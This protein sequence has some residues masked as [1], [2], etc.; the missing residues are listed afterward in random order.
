MRGTRWLLLVAILAI[1]CGVGLTYRAQKRALREHA[2]A[3]PANLPDELNSAAQKWVYS[4]TTATYTK[5]EA[6]ADD[7]REARDSSRVDLKGVTMKI[8]SKNGRTY[9][10]VRSA[11]ASFFK[12]DHR[13]RSADEVEITLNIPEQGPIKRTP[14]SIK[15]SGVELDTESG[16]VETEQPSRFVF[17]NGTGNA[18]GASYDP[19]SHQLLMKKDVRL[20]WRAKGPH[21][22]P[23]RVEG[24]SLEYHEDRSEVWLRP[25][26][27]LTRE[28]TVIEGENAVIHLED[29]P[30]GKVVRKIEV[31]NAHG[32]DAYP[33]RTLHYSA[34]ELWTELDD[35]GQ[36]RK[37]TAQTNAR[38]TAVSNS[39]ETTITAFHVEMNFTPGQGESILTSVD[40]SGNAEIRS[41]PLAAAGRPP[42]E[43]HAL[44]AEK[45]EM[46]MREG[47]R[48]ISS[49]TA[50]TPGVLEFIPNQPS[51]HHRVL[52]GNHMVILYGP[53]NRI[54]SFHAT[55]VRTQTDP[56]AE[57][58]KRKRAPR[59]TT[60]QEILASFD[61]T[62]K[63]GT[64]Q[65]T[66]D[67]R[68]EE[69]ERRAQAAKAIL[70]S[71]NDVILLETKARMWDSSGATSADRIRLDERTGAFSAEGEVN[72][73]HLPDRNPKSPEMLS[74]DEPIQ[75]QAQSMESRNRN[76]NIR[77]QGHAVLWQGANRIQ[78]DTIDLDR[79]KHSLV[80]DGNVM[81]SLW[82]QPAADAGS[83]NG[84][85]KQT[86]PP[87]LTE[88]HAPH[89][90]YT[91]SNRLAD[92][93]GGVLLQRP[94]LVVRAREIHAY[95]A[96]SGSDSRLEKA[97]AD[98]AVDIL[99]TSADRTRHGT[100]EH[101]EYYPGEQKIVLR[102]G[103]PKFADSEQGTTVAPAGLIYWVDDDRLLLNGSKDQ[104]VQTRL[105][106]KK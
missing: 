11:A 30:E 29:G 82:E 87:V 35:S 66:G 70:D 105:K 58:A 34:G 47:G 57:E 23:M 27:R 100:G 86:A 67:F 94:N 63:L 26:G 80:A 52:N 44:R 16:R 4:E 33:Q 53:Q 97:I 38:L 88:V 1:L 71:G 55:E 41:R 79:E 2:P 75:A 51:Q 20:E 96:E 90:E 6:A 76:R 50:W 13:L 46:K 102:G 32:N 62:G 21:A 93:S 45:I 40:A 91:G 84:K 85:P 78:A 25:W 28:N 61:K 7:F 69:G 95:L 17:E 42:R 19:T 37:I 68:Y 14:V 101:S 18:T 60:S 77:Y 92:Y 43:T 74:G 65:Q 81:T 59:I 54:E 73:S 12:G 83:Q 48:E 24:G 89:L 72:S 64:I 36:I 15:S 10:L 8:H 56:T 3:K 98:G 49:V 106:R 5:I 103:T 39:S 31:V 9:N 99:Q 22:K 104:P